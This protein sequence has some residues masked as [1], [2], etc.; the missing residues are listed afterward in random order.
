MANLSK[1]FPL[2]GLDKGRATT[3][4]PIQTTPD[5]LNVRPFDTDDKRFRGGQRPGLEK[6]PNEDD[7]VQLGGGQPVVFI[8]SISSVE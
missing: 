3:D 6:W 2:Q 1:G 7:A 5:S 8:T 4:Q